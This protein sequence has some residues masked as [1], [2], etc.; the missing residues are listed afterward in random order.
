MFPRHAR[1]P[2]KLMT[3]RTEWL[4]ASEAYPVLFVLMDGAHQHHAEDSSRLT[5]RFSRTRRIS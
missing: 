2:R 4:R 3:V 1:N 5:E